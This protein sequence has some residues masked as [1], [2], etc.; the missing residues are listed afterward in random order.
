[1][2]RVKIRELRLRN[3]KAF[4]DVS[5]LLE[6]VTFL[7]GRN[8][9]GKTTLL[10]GFAF[11]SEAVTDSLSAALERRGNLD[12]I[13]HR[14]GERT[15]RHDVSFGVVMELD[16]S[17]QADY[18]FTLESSKRGGFSVRSEYLSIYEKGG[19]VS[20]SSFSREGTRLHIPDRQFV[21]RVDSEYLVF[22][23]LAGSE[24]DWSLV[25]DTLKNV[26]L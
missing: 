3:Y 25:F 2:S 21:P 15:P 24:R 7:V 19:A 20:V 16:E 26:K 23:R 22:P 13:R 11:V 14:V 18:R 1:M 4:P 8:G 17:V 9:S 10:D 5:L 6:E 12:G